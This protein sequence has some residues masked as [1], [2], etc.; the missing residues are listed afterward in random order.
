MF[1]QSLFQY[2][3]ATHRIH[4]AYCSGQVKLKGR[5]FSKIFD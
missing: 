5:N 2:A 1:T 4:L 3:K